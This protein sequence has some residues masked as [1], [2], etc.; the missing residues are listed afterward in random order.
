LFAENAT[1][2]IGFFAR[3][4]S[5]LSFFDGQTI[6]PWLAI[7]NYGNNFNPSTGEFVAPVDGLYFF[8]ASTGPDTSE[9]YANIRLKASGFS[10]A[11]MSSTWVRK[12]SN[13]WSM[14]SVHGTL[15][16]TKGF[17]VWLMSYNSPSSFDSQ[18]TSFTGFLI[19]GDI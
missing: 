16:L 5:D 3:L 7:T 14:G 17:K 2:Q 4:N 6:K 9:A 1:K 8:V 10:D 18:S 13:Y 19:S 12:Y 11:Y 15:H